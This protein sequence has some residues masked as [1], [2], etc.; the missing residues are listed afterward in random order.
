MHS[1]SLTVVKYE[2]NYEKDW[3]E[4]IQENAING[5]FLHTRRFLNYHPAGRFED[6][7]YIVKDEK[8]TI[9]AVCPA[10]LHRDE[11]GK[12][13]YSHM[14]STYGGIV[15]HIKWYKVEKVIEIIQRLEETWVDNGISKVYLKQTPSLLSLGNQDLLEYCLY[16]LGYTSHIELNMYVDFEEHKE[17]IISGLAQ[18][19]R[20][21]V[22]NCEKAGCVCRR[23]STKREIERFRELHTLTLKKYD[24]EPT[25]S[26]EE[27]YE[28][29]TD[30]L[31]EES[32]LY[33]IYIGDVMVAGAMMFFFNRVGV[34][35]TQ[36]LCADPSYNRLSPMTYTYYVM[37]CEMKKRG[38]K[39]VTWGIVTDD[40][41]KYLNRGLANSKEAFGSRH[42]I[43]ITYEKNL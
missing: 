33:G 30:R 3:D 24:K 27:L 40:M 16:Y 18:G 8:G 29:V 1:H 14:G 43:N 5:T 9:I 20:T 10:C 31:Y 41:G 34:A 25:H 32:G 4:F 17:D 37:L 19:K 35:H 13:L 21:N 7:S 28:F 38:F 2:I 36:Y 6:M 11:Q 23:I 15:V 42:T 12:I 39:K 26:V 22:H